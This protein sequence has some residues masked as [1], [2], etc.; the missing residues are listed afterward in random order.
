VESCWEQSVCHSLVAVR[1]LALARLVQVRTAHAAK[2]AGQTRW[3]KHLPGG[4]PANPRQ[5]NFAALEVLPFNK[6]QSGKNTPTTHGA[7]RRRMQR[8]VHSAR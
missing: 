7:Q 2:W 4:W 8:T 3:A 6:L 5:G 1:L